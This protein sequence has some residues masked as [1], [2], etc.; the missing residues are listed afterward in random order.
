MLRLV[1]FVGDQVIASGLVKT[2]WSVPASVTVSANPK[3]RTVRRSSPAAG[4]HVWPPSWLT[5]APPPWVPARTRPALY[6]LKAIVVTTAVP[7]CTEVHV[8]PP[9]VLLNSEPAE[10]P[11]R[12]AWLFAGS[13]AR[14]KT[15]VWPWCGSGFRATQV[16]FGS[17]PAWTP[18]EPTASTHRA[19]SVATRRRPKSDTSQPIIT[20][21]AG[22]AIQGAT[23][24][25][26]HAAPC[27]RR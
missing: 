9:S 1:R 12:T 24:A 4:A 11:A 21:P 5:S 25:S 8:E 23:P 7:E 10:L 14:A 22:Q 17:A 19:P 6:G 27:P 26:P 18:A 20:Q 2:P 13:T 16:E 15:A 3:A